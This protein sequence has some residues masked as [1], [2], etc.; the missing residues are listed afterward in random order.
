L[1]GIPHVGTHQSIIL[2]S[3]KTLN[4]ETTITK[5][6]FPTRRSSNINE[7]INN[8]E[9]KIQNNNNVEVKKNLT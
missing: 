4:N 5:A 1:K 2:F 8:V 3:I 6:F 7:M 9:T